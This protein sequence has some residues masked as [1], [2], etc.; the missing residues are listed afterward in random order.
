[1]KCTHRVRRQ[2]HAHADQPLC[3]L[4]VLLTV[5]K[6]GFLQHALNLR[7]QLLPI[8]VFR[9]LRIITRI[10]CGII[11]VTLSGAVRSGAVSS[12]IKIV[13]GGLHLILHHILHGAF[14]GLF[15]PHRSLK[16]FLSCRYVFFGERDIMLLKLF[17]QLSSKSLASRDLLQGIHIQVVGVTY[18]LRTALHELRFD[19]IDNGNNLF[20]FHIAGMISLLL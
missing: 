14:S 2:R 19:L 13:Y 10:V 4:H 12:H 6:A 3:A 5:L 20:Y 17:R 16:S 1:M 11:T 8:I 15:Q 18:H 9:F 7:A